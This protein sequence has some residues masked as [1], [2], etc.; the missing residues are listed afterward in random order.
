MQLNLFTV[1]ILLALPSI[2]AEISLSE[3]LSNLEDVA[4]LAV[5]VYGLVDNLDLTT[6]LTSAPV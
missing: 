2:H 1:T 4:A 6:I 3:V 5:E